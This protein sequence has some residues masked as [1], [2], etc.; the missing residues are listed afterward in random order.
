MVGSG[1]KPAS[2]GSP[3]RCRRRGEIGSR[4][5]RPGH[6]RPGRPSTVETIDR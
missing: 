6:Q 2:A 4:R 5:K 1:K 3:T